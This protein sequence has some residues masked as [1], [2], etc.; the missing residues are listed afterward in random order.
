MLHSILTRQ[1]ADIVLPLLNAAGYSD[2]NSTFSIVAVG[3][4]GPAL[5]EAGR[6]PIQVLLLDLAAGPGLGT[7]VLSY[8]LRNT[9]AASQR[10]ILL[11]AGAEPGEP[12]IARIVQAQVYDIVT[13]LE[14]LPTV[15][16]KPAADLTAAVRWLD[17]RLTPSIVENK[18]RTAQEV[19]YRERLI[20][21][22]VITVAG[23]GRAVGTTTAA[24]Q[25]GQLLA[26][27]GTVAILEMSRFPVFYSLAGQRISRAN[28]QLFPQT[29]Q[30]QLYVEEIENLINQP[31]MR[32]YQYV[33]IDMGAYWEVQNGGLTFHPHKAEMLRA[34]LSVLV[35][36]SWP[37]QLLDLRNLYDSRAGANLAAWQ[38]L[39]RSPADLE[40]AKDMRD[41]FSSATVMPHISSPTFLSTEA[42]E[43]LSPLLGQ[44]IPA[45]HSQPKTKGF[46]RRR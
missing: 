21:N 23:A 39:L 30:R 16:A 32:Q 28:V 14:T 8:R 4:G 18:T 26:D 10:I 3:G 5:I 31:E 41:D 34:D 11:A 24:L 1:T 46:F 27:H 19:V 9:S 22:S 37:W 7:A 45:D 6:V 35:C 25:I 43:A 36:G 42:R 40:F 29:K 2:V 44:L 17:P 12:E 20:G 13:D 38:L 33:V 15:L